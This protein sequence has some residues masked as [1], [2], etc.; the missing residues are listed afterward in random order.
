MILAEN[1]W[2]TLRPGAATESQAD[3][4]LGKPDAIVAGVRY[5]AIVGLT[6]HG[7]T[8]KAA[9]L[10]FRNGQLVVLALGP[11]AGNGLSTELADWTAALGGAEPERVLDSRV[12]KN[13]RLRL[14]ASRGIA[15]HVVGQRVELVEL[16]PAASVESYMA[17]LYV[18]P[19]VFRK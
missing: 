10:Y 13:A 1:V 11:N 15:L 3:A 18:A 17:H 9:S 5:G 19:P 16:F 8:P 2:S 12:D 7:Y 14:Y 4:A 6:L